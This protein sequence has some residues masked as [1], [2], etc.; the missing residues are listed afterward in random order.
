M[1]GA[2]A[3]RAVIYTAICGGYDELKPAR[4]HADVTCDWVA[5]TDGDLPHDR[6]WE[7]RRLIGF[8][9]GPRALSRIPKAAPQRVFDYRQHRWA[10]WIDGGVELLSEGFAA[11]MIA[12]MDGRPLG[13]FAHPQ[14]ES[15]YDEAAVCARLKKYEDALL[16]QQVVDYRAAGFLDANGLWGCTVL[17]WDLTHPQ[18]A[19]LSELWWAQ[20]ERY[21][22]MDQVSLPFV[23]WRLGIRTAQLPGPLWGN[24]WFRSLKHAGASD[25]VRLN[26]GW[27][28]RM[29]PGWVNVDITPGPGVTVADLR[30]PWPWADGTVQ[31]V[32]AIDVIEHLPDKIH[33]MN[34][35]WRVLADGCRVEIVVPTTDGPGAFQD[36]THVSYWNRGS[37]KYFDVESPYW[38]R[39]HASYGITAQF[40]VM[41]E[42]ML[43]TVDGPKL[44]IA[45]AAVKRE[46][47]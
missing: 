16:E 22:T 30:D 2:A 37:F 25:E 11:A 28:D 13:V 44:Q 26:L 27:A 34:E 24:E 31:E 15:V 1:S 3:A 4:P 29:V 45:L 33:T 39:F 17:V 18:Q 20:Q 42:R 14:R 32:L 43:E 12:A 46:L 47:I 40:V 36:P 6:G 7:V 9:Q 21:G 19:K 41:Q 35:L 10:I 38:R 8:R 5:F 23:L